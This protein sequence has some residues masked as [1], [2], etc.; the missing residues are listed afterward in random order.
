MSGSCTKLPV[1]PVD[2]MLTEVTTKDFI[3][4]H[5]ASSWVLQSRL[6]LVD[7][8]LWFLLRTSG[9]PIVVL[10]CSCLAPFHSNSPSPSQHDGR[11][12]AR[13]GPAVGPGG[14]AVQGALSVGS[15]LLD[16]QC[17][18]H[19]PCRAQGRHP[20]LDLRA[21]MALGLGFV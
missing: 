17:P 21:G 4:V 18:L 8:L 2:S 19:P 14:H 11:A 6:C 13:A 5:M 3:S 1:T 7:L 20:V 9:L 15:E 12:A 10:P 16:C